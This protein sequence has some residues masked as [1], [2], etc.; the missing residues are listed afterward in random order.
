MALERDELLARISRA[1]QNGEAHVV[2]GLLD[3][4]QDLAGERDSYWVSDA[5][6]RLIS[7]HDEDGWTPLHFAA[8]G[9]TSQHSKIV[10][11][12]CESRANV[13]AADNHGWTPLHVAAQFAEPI[14]I[15]ELIEHLADRHIHDKR[16][17]TPFDCANG[18]ERRQLLKSPQ[19]LLMD[20]VSD[21]KRMLS[22]TLKFEMI[23]DRVRRERENLCNMIENQLVL[24]S[25]E[26]DLLDR[27]VGNLMQQPLKPSTITERMDACKD[28]VLAKADLQMVKEDMQAAHK[29]IV[30][31]RAFMLNTLL[32][33]AMSDLRTRLLDMAIT[34]TDTG[35]PLTIQ[36]S[37]LMLTRYGWEHLH[38]A[39]MLSKEDHHSSSHLGSIRTKSK[40]ADWLLEPAQDIHDKLELILSGQVPKDNISQTFEEIMKILT[41]VAD[42]GS[43]TRGA[44]NQP[45]NRA[46]D[47]ACTTS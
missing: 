20:Y 26:A 40:P 33:S 10:T 19:T 11:M 23:P 25:H 15:K 6:S 4:F 47:K 29:V 34:K 43:H 8:Q 16:D 22:Q 17:L 36:N 27:K 1:A 18:D 13:N 37:Q 38:R 2:R 32:I 3:G 21:A 24:T 9:G 39:L 41:E 14:A 30:Q 42:F 46:C 35:N 44:W 5:I 7:E 31:M 28:L 45:R 12:L